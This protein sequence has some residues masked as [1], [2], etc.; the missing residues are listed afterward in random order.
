[1]T[2]SQQLAAETERVLK[3]FLYWPTIHHYTTGA[4]FVAAASLRDSNGDFAPY[5]IG[6]PIFISNDPETGKSLSTDILCGLIPGGK[7]ILNP[8][9]HGI[10]QL[11]NMGGVP[12]IHE[13]DKKLG[14]RGA[15][16]QDTMS[17]ILGGY[18][19]GQSIVQQ[20]SDTL[21]E[22]YI[23]GPMIL[24]GNN[25]SMIMHSEGYAPFRSRAHV[26]LLSVPPKDHFLHTFN[27]EIHD[28]KIRGL[29]KRWQRWG[30]GTHRAILGIDVDD[31]IDPRI[32]NRQRQIWTILYRVAEY[33]G[34]EWPARCQAAARAMALGEY[35]EDDT[36][37]LS[38]ADELLMWVRGV[39]QDDETF[40]PTREIVKRIMTIP[41][42]M[43]WQRE[44]KNPRAAS[45]GLAGILEM[46]DIHPER[47]TYLGTQ[48]RGYALDN[49]DNLDHPDD[50]DNLDNQEH[51]DPPIEEWNWSEVDA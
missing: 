42:G 12:G 25:A 36:P 17:I 13:I 38:P 18:T 2:E 33:L 27:P 5:A 49:L 41:D 4:L 8:T 40:V 14:M 31:I 28:D 50:V 45:M 19:K 46:W 23:S 43:W 7:S 47:Q 22:V 35:G 32:K 44:W 9:S 21:D 30:V 37:T 39:F 3:D 51:V 10:A 15:R 1:M 34:G 26:F 48:E 24:N 16:N 20:R 6:R 29:R 11:I